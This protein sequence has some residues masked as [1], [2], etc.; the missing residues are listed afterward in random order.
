MKKSVLIIAPHP[1]DFFISCAGFILEFAKK[2]NFYVLCMTYKNIKPKSPI[3][4]KEEKNAISAL[5][6]HANTQIDLD[7]FKEGE[8]TKLYKKY[9]EM[10]QFIEN[11]ITER[12]HELILCPYTEDTHQDHRETSNA[13]LS[14]SRYYRNIIFYETPSTMNFQPSLFVEISNSSAATKKKI[15]KNY[16]S[17][18]IG[19]KNAANYRFTL[20]DF[21]NAK[22]ISNGA[23][24][25]TCKYAE[26]YRPYRLF[27]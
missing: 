8:D 24:S 13:T 18:I 3:R 27:L 2:F 14:A 19:G 25:K 21:I 1:D 16:K 20:S 12:K 26:G 6:K 9:K 17:Q 4:I 11:K 5:A 22:L 23:K 7:F 10:I 15:S